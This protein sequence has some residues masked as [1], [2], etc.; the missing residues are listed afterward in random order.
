MPTE[1]LRPEMARSTISEPV[2]IAYRDAIDN[3]ILCKKQQWSVAN[4]AVLAFAAM[5][6]ISKYVERRADCQWT[7]ILSVASTLSG[8]SG[9]VVLT[10]IQFSIKKFRN[11]LRRIYGEYFSNYERDLLQLKDR[12][13][14]FSEEIYIYSLLCAAIIAAGT[15]TI[16][17]L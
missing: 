9:I 6:G 4:Y 11:R 2:K 17:L 7:I 1:D 12:E 5:V 14:H 3:I 13:A 10:L 16:A 15:L 8:V